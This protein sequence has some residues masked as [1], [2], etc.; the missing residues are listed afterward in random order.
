MRPRPGRGPPAALGRPVGRPGDAP[1]PQDQP[2]RHAGLC[3]LCRGTQ[4]RAARRRCGA[5]R[6]FGLRRR[7]RHDGRR[8]GG[9]RRGRHAARRGRFPARP[10]PRRRDGRNRRLPGGVRRRCAAAV[11]ARRRGPGRADH[12]AI[13]RLLRRIPAEARRPRPERTGADDRSAQRADRGRH[14]RERR[15]DLDGP[16]P[17]RRGN[18]RGHPHRRPRDRRRARFVPPR[19]PGLRHQRP[20]PRRSPRRDRPRLPLPARAQAAR[21][22]HPGRRAA[23]RNLRRPRGPPRRGGR[24]DGRRLLRRPGF[25]G[26][27]VLR[28]AQAGTAG[29][30][31]RARPVR[32]RARGPRHLLPLGREPARSALL[33]RR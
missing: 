3:G 1:G 33:R 32:A 15:R 20:R 5:V 28:D 23:R 30:R 11:P 22:H 18:R 25:A 14:R 19:H 21:G 13:L 7:R 29:A 12:P 16:L 27:G 31:V 24:P 9:V 6:R 2:H 26:P 17:R 10:P 4:G 8:L